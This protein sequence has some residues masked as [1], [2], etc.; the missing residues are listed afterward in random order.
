MALPPLDDLSGG[1]RINGGGQVTLDGAAVAGVASGIA[2]HSANNV[3]TGINFANFSGGGIEITGAFAAGN[4]IF[5]CQIGVASRNE[6]GILIQ[7]GAASNTI[8][9]RTA[10]TRNIISGNGVASLFRAGEP[11]RTTFTA[12]TSG[13]TPRA[14]TR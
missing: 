11:R 5:N 3:I 7:G 2:V 10:S 8:G 4:E 13:R 1:T 9:G 12:T 6:I 14:R